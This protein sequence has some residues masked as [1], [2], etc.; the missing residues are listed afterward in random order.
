[1]AGNGAIGCKIQWVKT[2]RIGQSNTILNAEYD[3]GDTFFLLNDGSR[4]NSALLNDAFILV[5]SDHDELIM[6]DDFDNH[7]AVGTGSPTDTTAHHA[8]ALEAQAARGRSNGHASEPAPPPAPAPVVEANP[9]ALI[10]DKRKSDPV[11]VALTVNIPMP[12]PGLVQLLISD[13]DGTL[14]DIAAYIVDRMNLEE[15][16]GLLK[17][18]VK[19][20]ISE[21]DG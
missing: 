18:S 16:K 14:D 10:L 6:E 21:T 8:A 5:M 17:E 19:S 11:P 3:S 9:I 4:V 2:E 1:M 13:F 20:H 7:Y 12:S 15:L